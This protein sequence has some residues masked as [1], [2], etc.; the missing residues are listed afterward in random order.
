MSVL[1]VGTQTFRA[2]SP[3]LLVLA[4]V[5]FLA[6]VRN[7]YYQIR[8]ANLRIDATHVRFVSS[9]RSWKTGG[10]RRVVRIPLSDV[11]AVERRMTGRYRIS[12]FIIT[13]D[14][15]EFQVFGA[16]SEYGLV[17]SR[18]RQPD[19]VVEEIQNILFGS[20]LQ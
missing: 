5:G 11:K 9:R 15:R 8:Y 18:R 12:L 14:G 10:L 17:D 6:A 13:F 2:V 16:I 1:V 20:Q 3:T 7:A 19:A 4:S